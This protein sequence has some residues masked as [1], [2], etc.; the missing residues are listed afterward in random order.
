MKS[1]EIFLTAFT[2]ALLFLMTAVIT[3]GTKDDHQ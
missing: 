1:R 3:P 2:V